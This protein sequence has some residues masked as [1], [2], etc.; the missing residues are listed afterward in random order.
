MDESIR[1]PVSKRLST[2]TGLGAALFS[3]GL[4]LLAS[5]GAYYA[6]GVVANL[7]LDD[8]S[9]KVERP[10][11]AVSVVDEPTEENVT[12]G[13]AKGSLLSPEGL[14]TNTPSHRSGD[15]AGV[16]R[17]DIRADDA[18]VARDA[19]AVAQEES[20][21]TRTGRDQV[22]VAGAEVG[23]AAAA[24]SRVAPSPGLKDG[25]ATA[26]EDTSR[27][28]SE[29]EP[30]SISESGPF[31]DITAVSSV[32]LAEGDGGGQAQGPA[33]ESEIR[34]PDQ[35]DAALSI[36][37]DVEEADS[38]QQR[39]A[40]GDEVGVSDV[41]R[42]QAEDFV[43]V[44]VDFTWTLDDTERE[45]LGLGPSPALTLLA[46]EN[47]DPWFQSYS[48]S[49]SLPSDQILSLRE[50]SDGYSAIVSVELSGPQPASR[51]SI[52]AIEVDSEVK[53]LKVISVGNSAAWE[54]PQRVIGHIPTTAR[55][56]VRGQGW[57][58]GHLESPVSGGGNVFQ[59]LPE[60]PKL[61]HDGETVRVFLETNTR[62]YVYQV[63]ET[64]WVP[65][66]RLN[67]TDSGLHDITLVTCWPR[68]HYD[69]RLLVIAALVDVVEI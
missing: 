49:A 12:E 21:T 24:T 52:P 64:R 28:L 18:P 4:L 45:G 48:M 43:G 68:F 57:Y 62:R 39:Q 67:I 63:Y 53:E 8:L 58:F 50:E 23:A 29:P 65:Q 66:E 33:A 17:P 3:L 27:F 56:S 38:G 41:S 5:A 31:L 35:V 22:P 51:I 2:R 42:T 47:V 46:E 40:G 61:L 30:L 15:G 60:I 6:Y 55:P 19:L 10:S 9:Y 44:T 54:T 16:K 13:A 34:G 32:P 25:E 59:R 7:K 11:L 36:A 1:K 26:G 69:K 20:E 37:G 14:D